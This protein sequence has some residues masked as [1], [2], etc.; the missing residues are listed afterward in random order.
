MHQGNLRI[1][2]QD[3]LFSNELD[4]FPGVL[5]ENEVM[6]WSKKPVKHH[7]V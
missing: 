2:W 4:Y 3:L 7:V 1:S 6:P 5:I